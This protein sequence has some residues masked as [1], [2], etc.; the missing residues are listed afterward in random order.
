MEVIMK[1]S[2]MLKVIATILMLTFMIQMVPFSAIAAG[3]EITEVLDPESII[4]E[5]PY[6]TTLEESPETKEIVSEE[7]AKRSENEKHFK[8]EDG[9]FVIAQY[10]DAVH[11]EDENGNWVDID[12]TLIAEEAT[13]AN[14]FD[15]YTNKDNDFNVKLAENG[16][17]QLLR[18]E[19]DD[20]SIS[21]KLDEEDAA[22]S[23]ITVENNNNV[24]TITD[25]MSV[26]EKNDQT[27]QLDKL[28]SKAEYS[29]ILPGVDIEYTVQSNRVK[30]YIVVNERRDDY[31]F[32]FELELGNLVVRENE[33][34][35][36]SLMTSDDEEKY[37]IPA[38]YMFDA[39]E[40]YS[41]AVSYA[42]TNIGSGKYTMTVTADDAWINTDET[43]F[44]VKIDPTIT[45]KESRIT[46]NDTFV[47]SEEP[48]ENKKG[49]SYLFVGSNEDYG[50]TRAYIQWILP[51]RM[52][53]SYVVTSAKLYYN[54]INNSNNTEIIA[55]Q[56]TEFKTENDTEISFD[57][58]T[59][60]CQPKFNDKILS[61]TRVPANTQTQTIEIDITNAV[62]DEGNTQ[63]TNCILLMR[64]NEDSDFHNSVKL[65][66]A[67]NSER[68]N[69]PSM[70]ISYCLPKGLDSEYSFVPIKLGDTGIAYI[71]AYNGD[72]SY[73]HN[74]LTT[75]AYTVKHVFNPYMTDV[76]KT[77]GTV[78]SFSCFY[79]DMNVGNGW[80]LSVQEKIVPISAKEFSNSY[81]NET[82]NSTDIYVSDSN[83]EYAFGYVYNNDLG[84]NIYFRYLESDS[85]GHVR[86]YV[87]QS[88]V[89][90]ELHV[91]YKDVETDEKDENEN[92]IIVK[93]YDKF[94]LYTPED[95][96]KTFGVYGETINNITRYVGY[97]TQ[98]DTSTNVT[99]MYYTPESYTAGQSHSQILMLASPPTFVPITNFSYD[100]A[101]K[102]LTYI[103]S[104]NTNV[105]FFYG[106]SE[107]TQNQLVY[108]DTTDTNEGTYT[109]TTFSYYN[110]KLNSVSDGKGN[111]VTFNYVNNGA[112]IKS[113]TLQR[114]NMSDTF[115]DFTFSAG[116]TKVHYYGTD[117]INDSEN[118]TANTDDIYYTYEFD[119]HGI[120][121]GLIFENS[122]IK[123]AERANP[124][125]IYGIN[126][127]AIND[128]SVNYS[129]YTSDDSC[130]PDLYATPKFDHNTNISEM[131]SG[132]S[133][134][135]TISLSDEAYNGRNSYLISTVTYRN[136]TRENACLT[137]QVILTSGVHTFSAYVKCED[138]LY[139]P[140]VDENDDPVYTPGYIKLSVDS[141]NASTS[142]VEKTNGWQKLTITF[143][144]NAPDG[145][146]QNEFI[147]TLKILFT[148]VGDILVDEIKI[149]EEYLYWPTTYVRSGVSSGFED[150]DVSWEVSAD[151]TYQRVTSTEN[152]ANYATV[153]GVEPNN[154]YEG[155]YALKIAGEEDKE[156]SV[157][158]IHYLNSSNRPTKG[159]T[160]SGWGKTNS[161]RPEDAENY[162]FELFAYYVYYV[163]VGEGNIEMRTRSLAI[164][165]DPNSTDWQYDSKFFEIPTKANTGEE[166]TLVYS[167]TFGALY[168]DATGNAYFDN[169]ELLPVTE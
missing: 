78:E 98:S 102:K 130:Y 74:T 32:S 149:D 49:N 151:S 148:G 33:D 48:T 31:V 75:T 71:N 93:T 121:N 42:I 143:S 128:S 10:P 134:K 104:S 127:V 66:S 107:Q 91:I 135:N 161:T 168:K 15:G 147:T 24:A 82:N 95:T 21:M 160:L 52:L 139:I 169:I 8:L 89:G 3:D 154:V 164:P 141:S 25:D 113:V 53:N 112:K 162:G 87:D 6:D 131:Y 28:T 44:P 4:T 129:L 133:I 63:G 126:A 140:S 157:H 36:I 16:K 60:A 41:D 46:I 56:V 105:S 13:D 17:D 72:V 26:E 103:S 37:V 99:T 116:N 57:S 40:Q 47:S 145:Y 70:K 96:K 120:C 90:Y 81:P 84:T 115:V 109:R 101:T 23:F 166:V 2:K 43:V 132:N 108:I 11:Y 152:Y 97:I 163:D 79:Q 92:A 7:T 119:S 111:S 155:M 69:L 19:E 137:K 9:S 38:P 94:V 14:D 125:G 167:I 110:G 150:G 138:G 12:N 156:K 86:K 20:F 22:Q 61:R 136:P 59:Y 65:F 122:E 35:S 123:V 100:A 158:Y 30:E 29:D 51:D 146:T 80:S 55:H 67:Y 124:R 64:N 39:N 50:I 62:Y 88:D 83:G 118:T 159:F 85:T 77:D 18:I 76:I 73:I 117:G 27:M 106:T 142:I 58:I 68:T 144:L 153:V 5:I 34:G 45:T 114:K 165:F 54:L 1:K